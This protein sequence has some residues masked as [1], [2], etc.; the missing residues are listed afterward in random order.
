M[1]KRGVAI[2][3]ALRL[4]KRRDSGK[5]TFVS[6]KW[7]YWGKPRAELL[8]R[9]K[10]Y[11]LYGERCMLWHIWL[12]PGLR[13]EVIHP[14]MEIFPTGVSLSVNDQTGEVRDRTYTYPR[15][16]VFFCPQDNQPQGYPATGFNPWEYYE[17]RLHLSGAG[18]AGGGDGAEPLR[19]FGGGA[20]CL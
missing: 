16:R 10:A 20:D 17:N 3:S 5:R 9:R 6:R 13:V 11:N 12:W 18:V 4:V 19:S 7:R 15:Q 8:S 14:D 1:M 2:K